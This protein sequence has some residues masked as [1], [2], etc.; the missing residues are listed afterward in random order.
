VWSLDDA[1]SGTATRLW[2]LTDATGVGLPVAWD[3]GTTWPADAHDGMAYD[4]T[5][6][7]VVSDYAATVPVEIRRFDPTTPGAGTSVGAVHPTM[8]DTLG[9]AV[10]ATWFYLAGV[11]QVDATTVA[12]GVFRV[13]RA[14][15]GTAVPE[16]IAPMNL[17]SSATTTTTLTA[18]VAMAVDSTTAATVLYVRGGDGRLHVVADPGGAAPRHLGELSAL[19][20]YGD[21]AMAY[22]P[23]GPSIYLFE[24]ET[25]TTGNFVRL[26]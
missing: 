25:V 2:R 13:R 17:F 20:G 10:D 1:S 15:L 11:R 16:L 12:R 3:T 4:G 26:D 8:R 14:E 7:F 22:V 6:F 23:S 19:G 21:F 18:R 24:T 5:S 9:L